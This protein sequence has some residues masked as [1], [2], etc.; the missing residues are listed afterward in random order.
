[1]H[2]PQNKTWALYFAARHATLH[3]K[4]FFRQQYLSQPMSHSRYRDSALNQNEWINEW[5]NPQLPLCGL[6][7][8]RFLLLFFFLNSCGVFLFVF[9]FCCFLLLLFSTCSS[10]LHTCMDC[11]SG[12]KYCFH[13]LQCQA[14]MAKF[15]KDPVLSIGLRIIC[16]EL[17]NHAILQTFAV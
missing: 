14:D 11:S 2:E 12:L 17:L 9:V 3:T 5:M 1:M 15:L 10:F 16:W 7:S 4:V 6:F 8:S 13:I